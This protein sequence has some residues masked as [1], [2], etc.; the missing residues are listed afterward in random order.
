M[1]TQMR[2]WVHD[3]R[4]ELNR[5]G[6]APVAG[7]WMSEPDKVQWVDVATDLDCLAL[8]NGMGAWCG[9]VGVPPGHKFHGKGYDECVAACAEEYCYDHSPNGAVEVH[10]GLTFSDFCHESDKGEAFGICHTP[11]PGREHNVWWLGFDTAHSFDLTPYDAAKEAHEG[12][13]YP[14]KRSDREVYRTL[15]YVKAECAR[16]AG[17]LAEVTR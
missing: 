7:P 11:F 2:V 13:R 8:R 10:G 14:W 5:M 1:D 15:D 6:I 16:L 9:Y 12:F 4:P 17:Q 3:G